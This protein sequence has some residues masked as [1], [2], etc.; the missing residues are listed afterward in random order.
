METMYS[1][2]EK[3]TLRSE[4]SL[5]QSIFL[6]YIF[7]K[8]IVWDSD[9]KLPRQSLWVTG[10]CFLKDREHPCSPL[11]VPCTGLSHCSIVCHICPFVVCQT[12]LQNLPS[13]LPQTI[14]FPF[15]APFWTLLFFPAFKRRLVFPS[16][17]LLILNS[18]SHCYDFPSA[19]GL[20]NLLHAV[21]DTDTPQTW[22]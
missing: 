9:T 13:P 21:G 16:L 19:C 14:I 1:S 6:A 11:L 18:V 15:L 7:F 5:P 8:S 12:L 20:F 22:G 17:N 10:M 3:R 2:I 4:F